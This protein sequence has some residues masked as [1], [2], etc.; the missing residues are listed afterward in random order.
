MI[1]LKFIIILDHNLWRKY[2][3]DT[4]HPE[5]LVKKKKMVRKPDDA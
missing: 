1:L 2:I 5:K 4:I 3:T